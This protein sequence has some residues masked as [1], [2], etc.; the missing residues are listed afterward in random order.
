MLSKSDHEIDSIHDGFGNPVLFVDQVELDLRG[1]RVPPP[2]LETV[3]QA[4][5]EQKKVVRPLLDLNNVVRLR[6]WILVSLRLLA[7]R[8]VLES[9]AHEGLET[10]SDSDDHWKHENPGPY[11]AQ[12]LEFGTDTDTGCE[13]PLVPSANGEEVR[14]FFRLI[15]RGQ[16]EG[17]L[18]A[19]RVLL[20][21]G[22]LTVLLGRFSVFL[23]LLTML[24]GR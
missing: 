16:N 6:V 11:V 12:V 3:K 1:D 10:S 9:R 19:V 18:V 14:A 21:L 23:G 17:E 24:L 15:G 7:A 2:K 13:P 22:L 5:T 8:D 4:E 20:V